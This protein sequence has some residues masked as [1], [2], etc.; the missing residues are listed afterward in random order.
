MFF[1][2][3]ML[4]FIE[5]CSEKIGGSNKTVEINASMFGRRK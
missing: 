1:R 3:A 5:G 2:E 4:V